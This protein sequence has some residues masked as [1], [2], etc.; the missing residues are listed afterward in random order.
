[1]APVTPIVLVGCQSDTRKN[2]EILANLSKQGRAPISPEQA[3]TF[4]QQIGACMYVETTAKVAKT[5]IGA[6]EAAGLAFLG[7]NE[8]RTPS[9][10]PRRISK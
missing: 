8:K 9:P 6:F 3:L 1:M 2:R 5:T 10:K 4:S 7:K